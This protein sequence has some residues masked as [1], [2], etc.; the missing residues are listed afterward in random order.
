[1]YHD[2]L[3][4][5]YTVYLYVCV[6]VGW[7]M[8]AYI[9]ISMIWLGIYSEQ[10]QCVSVHWW[11]QTCSC[12][13]VSLAQW[14]CFELVSVTV[15]YTRQHSLWSQTGSVLLQ[16][17]LLFQNVHRW[18]PALN[19][20]WHFNFEQSGTQHDGKEVA[21]P[22]KPASFLLFSIL[23]RTEELFFL[24]KSCT[25]VTSGRGRGKGYKWQVFQVHFQKSR[26]VMLM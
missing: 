12:A 22:V 4:W 17:A 5:K 6:C 15:C 20:R 1:M 18:L 7:Y 21:Q 19:Q 9:Y 3:W 8:I 14:E 25:A 26:P 23:E 16:N 11:E 2:T 24:G 13:S 10:Q